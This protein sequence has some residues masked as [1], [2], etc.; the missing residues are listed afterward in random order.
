M[1]SLC[2][3]GIEPPVHISRGVSDTDSSV[4]KLS[5]KGFLPVYEYVMKSIS[6]LNEVICLVEGFLFAFR[7]LLY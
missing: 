1:E 2:E 6:V 4:D 7:G 5:D 3:C